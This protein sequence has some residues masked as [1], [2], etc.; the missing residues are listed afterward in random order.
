[1]GLF[2]KLRGKMNTADDSGITQVPTE[3]NTVYS[4]IAGELIA[5]SDF[6][7][8]CFSEGVLGLGCGIRPSEEVVKAPF[9]GQV[10]SLL[11]TYHALGLLSEDGVELL[12]HVGVD[13]VTMEGK[14]FTP[15]VNQ[16][17]KIVM[18]QE[19][20]KFK[21]AEIQAAG[22]DPS[23]AVIVANSNGYTKVKVKEP[24]LVDYSEPIINLI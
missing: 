12:I 23:V 19:L 11:D 13:T 21:T 9:N 16:G 15:L 4:P 6:P 22:F 3:K 10:V 14:G 17:D 18:G 2:N 8:E 20:L 1:M 24:G 5:L 7:D